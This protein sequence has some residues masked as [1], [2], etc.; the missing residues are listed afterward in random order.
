MKQLFYKLPVLFGEL[1]GTCGNKRIDVTVQSRL[2][3]VVH[4]LA[5][6]QSAGGGGLCGLIVSQTV[7]RQIRVTLIKRVYLIKSIYE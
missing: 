4:G 3:F 1:P 7:C 2:S 6:S 5:I